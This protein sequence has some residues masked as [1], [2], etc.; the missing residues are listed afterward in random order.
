MSKSRNFID[1][2]ITFLIILIADNPIV[3]ENRFFNLGVFFFLLLVFIYRKLKLDSQLIY[4]VFCVTLIIVIQGFQ[5][6][7]S[8]FTMMTFI[9]LVVLTPYLAI[10]IVGINYLRITSKIVYYVSIISLF[11]YL[12]QVF[13][14]GVTDFLYA[15]ESNFAKYSSLPE[16]PSIFIYSI[17]MN[18]VDEGNISSFLRNPGAFHEPGAFAVFIVLAIVINIMLDDKPF[19]K[20]NIILLIAL[21]TTF[22]TAGFLGI[23]LVYL[24]Y[25]FYIIRKD[26]RVLFVSSIVF[27]PLILYVMQLPFM[28]NKIKDQVMEQ[29]GQSL[30]TGTSGRILGARKAIV[31]LGRYPFA[32]RGLTQA[33]RVTDMTSDEAAGYGYMNFYSQIGIVFSIFYTIYFLKAMKRISFQYSKDIRLWLLLLVSLAINLFS[34]KFMGDSFFIMFLFIGVLPEFSFQNLLKYHHAK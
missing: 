21:I 16:R 20:K 31:V 9:V 30:S 27:I 1:F 12:G 4:V 5:W 11:L 3:V 14:P 15:I 2:L 26:V 24:V 6:D 33:S 34:Q 10:K 17:A 25:F 23:F 18:T 19:S 8:Y 32:G 22:S 29:S 13:I 7:I 28:A